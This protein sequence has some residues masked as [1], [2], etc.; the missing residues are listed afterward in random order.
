MATMLDSRRSSRQNLSGLHLGNYPKR[1]NRFAATPRERNQ[2]NKI[3]E[4][5]NVALATDSPV[6]LK[7]NCS[8]AYR[9]LYNL[10]R[11]RS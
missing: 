11:E 4:R 8:E 9:S 1:P 2:I 3:I 5:L 7:Y 6:T 10:L